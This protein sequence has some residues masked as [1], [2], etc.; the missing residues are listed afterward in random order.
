MSNNG[1]DSMLMPVI[2]SEAWAASSFKQREVS[3]VDAASA[4]MITR[5]RFGRFSVVAVAER[6]HA[7]ACRDHP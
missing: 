7:K 4:F 2:N 1:T 3:E 5:R 6:R